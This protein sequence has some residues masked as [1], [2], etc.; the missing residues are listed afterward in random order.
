MRYESSDIPVSW[1]PSEAGGGPVG[2]TTI[3]GWGAGRMP[4]A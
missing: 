2:S 3:R 4:A 1:I